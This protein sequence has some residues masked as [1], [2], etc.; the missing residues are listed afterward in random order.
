MPPA[1]VRHGAHRPERINEWDSGATRAAS[2]CA[3]DPPQA[4]R[5]IMVAARLP[6]HTHDYVRATAIILARP[7]PA[8]RVYILLD[9][10]VDAQQERF[11]NREA[12]RLG[13]R[14]IE[15]QIELGRL[16]DRNV[17]GLGPAQ[18]LVD[19]VGGA[20]IPVFEVWS[21]GHQATR[22]DV[23]PNALHR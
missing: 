5:P 23:V 3:W 6:L 22:F 7:G 15:N 11:R 9:Q 8:W 10:L 2:A 19:I 21:I 18:N 13:G 1:P 14:K 17:A 16:L 20:A 12:E 4:A